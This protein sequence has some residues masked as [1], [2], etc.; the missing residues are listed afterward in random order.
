MPAA[1]PATSA[2]R[3]SSCRSIPASIRPSGLVMSDVK[4]DYVRSRLSAARR[5]STPDEV[6]R[7]CSTDWWREARA[8]L[9]RGGF[10][11]EPHP[12]AAVRSTCA[13]PAR[14]T[15][16][17][18]RADEPLGDGGARRAA[19]PRS[20]TPAQGD[21]RPYRA[22]GAGRDRLL[23][24]ARRRPACRR[25]RCRA[26]RPS[27]AAG[28]AEARVRDGAAA[29]ALRRRRGTW[30]ATRVYQRDGD[31]CRPARGRRAG[32]SSSSSTAPP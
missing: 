5:R 19:P 1:S 6:E 13:M 10:A 3:A 8:E 4:H 20:T 25:W 17:P 15:R 26:S 16:S 9:R 12:H 27:G 32:R 24:G 14:A 31:R 29:R 30:I 28:A 22:G 11:V 21:V 23:P 7:A 2:W 18:C